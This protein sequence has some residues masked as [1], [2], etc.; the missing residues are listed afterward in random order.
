M[1]NSFSETRDILCQLTDYDIRQLIEAEDE[2]SRIGSF[3]RIFPSIQTRKYLKYF[4][5]LFYPNLL[6]DQWEQHFGD[7]R[8]KGLNQLFIRSFG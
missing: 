7:N 8:E 2:L 5:R 1:D 4:D 6:L 3:K